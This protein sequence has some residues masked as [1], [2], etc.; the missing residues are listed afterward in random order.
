[1]ASSCSVSL[2]RVPEGRLHLGGVGM[3]LRLCLFDSDG[4][5]HETPHTYQLCLLTMLL[6]NHGDLYG[7]LRIMISIKMQR[8][9]HICHS[10]K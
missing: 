3:M 10:S 8:A 7:R 4:K 5:T 9:K 1:M 6:L 2:R